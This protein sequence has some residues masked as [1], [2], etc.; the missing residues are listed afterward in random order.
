MLPYSAKETL[1]VGSSD[2]EIIVDYLSGGG[3][4]VL[5]RG[6]WEGESEKEQSCEGSRGQSDAL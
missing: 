4:R 3:E 2:G 5:M 1:K 6:R